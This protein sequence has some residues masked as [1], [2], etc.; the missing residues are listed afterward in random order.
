MNLKKIGGSLIAISKSRGRWRPPEACRSSTLVVASPERRPGAD[1]HDFDPARVDDPDRIALTRRPTGRPVMYQAGSICCSSTGR[2]RPTIRRLLPPALEVDLFE[3]RAY[4]RPGP[5]HDAGGPARRP[6][7]RPGDLGFPRDQRPD[8]RPCP[9]ARARGLVLQPRRR[10]LRRLHP[11]PLVV[12]P[13]LLHRPDGAGGRGVGG[14]ASGWP[15]PRPRFY[16]ARGRRRRRIEAEVPA[17][18]VPAAVGTLEYFLAERYLL[19]S[20]ARGGGLFTGGSTTR[21]YPLQVAEVRSL[22][23]SL[24]AASGIERP[25]ATPLAHYA[26]GVASRSSGWSGPGRSGSGPV[27]KR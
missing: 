21:P 20:A 2:S 9:G 24:L 18:V 23:E 1:R 26:R 12:P 7:E 3:G 16:P 8:L 14:R 19:Y 17:P 4:R 25:D 13:A 5:V 11:G 6:A 22:E 10:Q 27:R 15:T